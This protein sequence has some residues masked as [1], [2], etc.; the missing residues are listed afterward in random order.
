MQAGQ[1][2]AESALRLDARYWMVPAK[3]DTET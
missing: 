1:V 3:P 2:E